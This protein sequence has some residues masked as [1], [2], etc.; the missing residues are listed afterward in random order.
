MHSP[1]PDACSKQF[2]SL[3]HP[4]C[5]LYLNSESKV[6]TLLAPGWLILVCWAALRALPC[7]PDAPVCAGFTMLTPTQATC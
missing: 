2:F 6:A 4:I 5:L 7:C 1:A 3:F